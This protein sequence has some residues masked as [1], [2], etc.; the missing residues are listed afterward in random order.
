[1]EEFHISNSDLEIDEDTLIKKIDEIQKLVQCQNILP[2]LSGTKKYICI[3][4][5]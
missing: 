4:I 5:I 3:I 1:M 2:E